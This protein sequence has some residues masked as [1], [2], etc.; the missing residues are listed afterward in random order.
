MTPEL[1]IQMIREGRSTELLALIDAAIAS[2][3]K[4]ASHHADKAFVCS[5]LKDRHGAAENALR[6]SELA[7]DEPA[8]SFEASI[9]LAKNGRLQ[10]ADAC[11]SQSIESSKNASST[12]YLGTAHLLRAYYRA[13]LG[14]KSAALADLEFVKDDATFYVDRMISKQVVREL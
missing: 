1:K 10:E 9:Q 2:E 8:Y 13:R 14:K 7:P 11:A 3:P 6:A 12:Y 5:R 4:N